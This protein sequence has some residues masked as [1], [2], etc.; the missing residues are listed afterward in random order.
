MSNNSVPSVESKKEPK[1]LNDSSEDEVT[2]FFKWWQK[3]KYEE[4]FCGKTGEDLF[5][6][7]EEQL[8]KGL[9]DNLDG[10]ILYNKLHPKGESI[11]ISVLVRERGT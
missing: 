7:S 10:S 8:Q 9:N 11:E 4:R 2:A 3:G 6:L 5:S 1:I